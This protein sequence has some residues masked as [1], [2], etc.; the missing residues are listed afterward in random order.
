MTQRWLVHDGSDLGAAI[1]E[2][3]VAR[4]LTQEALAEQLGVTRSWLAKLERGR[5]NSMV[6]LLVRLLR[7]MGATIVVEFEDPPADSG[8]AANPPGL[9]AS[10]DDGAQ[11]G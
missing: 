3:R 5:T 10:H 6:N 9:G 1:G 8:S 4:D 7:S 11:R 2:I